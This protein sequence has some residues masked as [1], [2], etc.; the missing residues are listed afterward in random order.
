MTEQNKVTGG[1]ETILDHA[2]RA[3]RDKAGAIRFGTITLTL[4]DGKPT[5]LEV[6]EKQRFT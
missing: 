5:Q 1:G 2:L 4:H 3:I 6:S